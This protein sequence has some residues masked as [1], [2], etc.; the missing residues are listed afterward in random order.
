MLDNLISNSILID[1]FAGLVIYSFAMFL[2]AFLKRSNEF[3]T[4][5]LFGLMYGY[6]LGIRSL[7]MQSNSILIDVFAGIVISI[8]VMFLSAFVKRNNELITPIL[9]GVMFSNYLNI[10]SLVKLGNVSLNKK[11]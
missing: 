2:S 4:P 8:F 9:F 6:Y 11:R 5:I 10:R 3:R 7:V 1:A